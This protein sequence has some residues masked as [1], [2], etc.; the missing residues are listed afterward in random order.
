MYDFLLAQIPSEQ[1]TDRQ[2]EALNP[3]LERMDELKE[4][5]FD[6]T[7]L[8]ADLYLT[9]T[10]KRRWFLYFK[11]GSIKAVADEE[12]VSTAAVHKSLLGTRENEKSRSSIKSPVEKMSEIIQADTYIQEKLAEIKDVRNEIND[13]IEEYY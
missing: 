10:Q 4:K 12:G 13:I 5:L 7:L 8:Y 11:L 6:R 1:L 9:E 2:L 3:L